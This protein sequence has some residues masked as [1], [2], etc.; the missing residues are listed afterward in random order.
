MV[1]RHGMDGVAVHWVPPEAACRVA[2]RDDDLLTLST[3]V[4]AISKAFTSNTV[5]KMYITLLLPADHAATNPLV[6]VLV[7]VVDYV[8]V[9]THLLQLPLVPSGKLCTDVAK[10]TT[11]FIQSLSLSPEQEKKVC[12]GFSLSPYKVVASPI[13]GQGVHNFSY[14]SDSKL[15]GLRGRGRVSDACG[16]KIEPCRYA[17]LF[18]DCIVVYPNAAQQH[19]YYMFHKADTVQ[20][21]VSHVTSQARQRIAADH[22]AALF[23]LDMDN[24]DDRITCAGFDLPYRYLTHFHSSIQGRAS[25][26]QMLR[27]C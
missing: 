6:N 9:Q 24:W 8:I 16:N 18:S 5:S 4:D 17:L 14:D 13:V 7:N 20:S 27:R 2:G 23:D 19:L 22:C 1:V 15:D 12:S 11:D 21:I 26:L 3:I 10:N 25:P